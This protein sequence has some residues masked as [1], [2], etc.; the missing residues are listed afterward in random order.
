MHW[1]RWCFTSNN[2]TVSSHLK[3][4]YLMVWLSS[5]LHFTSFAF[6]RLCLWRGATPHN[7][8]SLPLKG[9]VAA[10]LQDGAIQRSPRKIGPF[11]CWLMLGVK[12]RQGTFPHKS[13]SSLVIYNIS[14]L[15]SLDYYRY[16]EI[17]CIVFCAVW[18]VGGLNLPR[19]WRPHRG[20]KLK[21]EEWNQQGRWRWNH[22]GLESCYPYIYIYI[23]TV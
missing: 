6:K 11:W 13:S 1:K 22:D 19:G 16:F 4:W 3:I 20:V 21:M 2:P 17:A 18:R 10:M 15:D 23:Y 14:Y 8:A 5:S 9:C 7:G 12:S